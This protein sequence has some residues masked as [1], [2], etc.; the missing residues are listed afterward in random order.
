MR[1]DRNFLYIWDQYFLIVKELRFLYFLALTGNKLRRLTKEYF[2]GKN[3]EEMTSP[4]LQELVL[5]SMS[6]DWAQ[7]DAL[8]PTLKNVSKLVLGR[9]NINKIS[10][11]FKIDTDNFESL[12]V[13]NL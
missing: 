10:S 7:V 4:R 3:V 5:N 12:T 2:E 8:A 11:G 9:N 6:L 1:L 13:L